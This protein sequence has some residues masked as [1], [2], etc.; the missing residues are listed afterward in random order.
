MKKVI[1]LILTVFTVVSCST[2]DNENESNHPYYQFSAS[3]RDLMIDYDYKEGDVLT[4]KNQDNELLQFRVVEVIERKARE[5]SRGTFSGGGGILLSYYDSKIIKLEINQVGED[6]LCCDQVNFIF[7]KN[8]DTLRFGIHFSLWNKST[9]TFID[10]SERGSVHISVNNPYE[11]LYQTM[12]INGI[13]Y[14]KVMH[15]ESDTDDPYNYYSD[16]SIYA[17][18]VFY[19]LN[20]GIVQF[21]DV[22]GK[23]W[24]L[25]NE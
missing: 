14:D 25:T 6:D 7:S 8:D 9:S 19:D 11:R 16:L 20:F 23:L 1:V 17:N 15:F 5:Y 24:S 10:S 4:Y 21:K 12:T 18:E 13:T 2:D 22:E 3:D